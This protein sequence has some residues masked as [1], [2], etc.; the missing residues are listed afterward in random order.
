[1]EIISTLTVIQR[2]LFLIELIHFKQVGSEEVANI[3]AKMVEMRFA[4]GEDIYQD[5]DLESN[6]YIVL[7]GEVVQYR[8]GVAVRRA[9]QGM[10][11]GLFGLMGIDDPSA[12]TMK[13][14]KPSHVIALSRDDFIDAMSEHPGF[15]FGF[16]RSLADTIQSYSQRIETLEKRLAESEGRLATRKGE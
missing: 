13:A 12:H 1:M 8:E 4:E 15:A 9:T 7:D 14:T 2:A 11:F 5:K 6:L 10:S 3:A 16:V